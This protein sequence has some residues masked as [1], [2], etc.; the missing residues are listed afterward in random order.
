MFDI[1]FWELAFIGVLALVVLGPK[2]LP[3]AAR[4]AGQWIGKM[5]RFITN[6]KQDLNQQL[7]ADELAEL[8]KLKAELAQ[9]RDALHESSRDVV[10]SIA[11]A[12]SDQQ[13]VAAESGELDFIDKALDQDKG[14]DGNGPVDLHGDYHAAQE[15]EDKKRLN[16]PYDPDQDPFVAPASQ[17]D[18]SKKDTASKSSG[19]SGKK[20]ATGKS[21]TTGGK[22][23]K[24]K[25]A[26][27]SD[28]KKDVS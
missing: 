4:I 13:G 16:Q 12:D 9:A 11:S 23:S 6:V 18:S 20:K 19:K 22:K 24:K 15:E 17:Q 3:E 2:R 14:G 27:R 5:R 10:N 28:S 7:A 8:R 26:K 25:V 21:K 1:G